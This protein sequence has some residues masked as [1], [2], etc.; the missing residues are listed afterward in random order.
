M[1]VIYHN[2]R[3]SKSR[4]ALQTLEE[5]GLN[6]TIIEYQKIELTTEQLKELFDAA[7]L[8]VQQ[9]IRTGEQIYKDLNLGADGVDDKQLLQAIINHPI[10]LNRPFVITS[11]GTR[12]ARDPETL[13]EIL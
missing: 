9:A 6:P 7:G 12:L 1:T 5:K 4:A 3:C 13:A 11:K 8:T 10:L 2:P